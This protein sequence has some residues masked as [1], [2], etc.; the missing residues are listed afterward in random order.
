MKV[1]MFPGQGSQSRGMGAELFDRYAD[2][3]RVADDILGYS[4][5]ELCT[6]DPERKL[7]RTEYTQPALYVVNALAYRR[8]MEE[9]DAP[10]DC[11]MGH[12]LG[13]YNALTAA[14]CLSFDMG[15]Q[16]VKRR[17]ELMSRADGGAMAA[18]LGGTRERVRA[19]LDESGLDGVDIANYNSRTQIVISGS[20]ADIGR[21]QSVFSEGGLMYYPLNT[22]GAFHSRLMRESSVEFQNY[23]EGFAFSAPDIE[24]VSN[25]TGEPYSSHDLAT[26]LARQIASEV[27]WFDGVRSLVT[28]AREGGERVE[29]KE[30][31][32]DKVLTKLLAKIVEEEALDG[33]E[34]IGV[35]DAVPASS[36]TRVTGKET[37]RRVVAPSETPATEADATS[38]GTDTEERVRRWNADHP[39]GTV[40]RSRGSGHERLTTR[41]AA[42]V[43]FGHRAAVYVEGFRGYFDVNELERIEEARGAHAG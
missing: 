14:G 3:T 33:C 32:N 8:E 25:V 16:L 4:V 35:P 41:S 38:S 17:G 40:V 27:R 30:V 43:L 6:V 18:V 1:I 42:S 10:P 5:K 37:P 24:V 15:L 36:G 34:V 29:F 26:V 13:E 7:N 9:R 23:L 22:S 21:A 28:R 31:G 20:V 11:L 12:S 19:C 2:A 39:V